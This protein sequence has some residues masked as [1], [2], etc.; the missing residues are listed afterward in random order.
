[1]IFYTLP[2]E[3]SRDFL[4][5]SSVS[6]NE[7]NGLWGGAAPVLIEKGFELREL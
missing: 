6:L 1:V 5:L 4:L 7:S 2:T 3:I